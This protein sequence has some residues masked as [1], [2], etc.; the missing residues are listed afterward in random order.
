MPMGSSWSEGLTGIAYEIAARESRLMRVCAGPGTGKTFAMMRR[1]GRF[2]E[3][4]VPPE[5]ILVVTFTRAAARDL[6]RSLV[7]IDHPEA[8]K[9]VSGTLHSHCF[10]VLQDEAV[11]SLTGRTPRPLLKHEHKYLEQDLAGA[12]GLKSSQTHIA[13]FEAEWARAQTDDPGWPTDNRDQAFHGELMGWMQFHQAMLIGELVSETRK[14][15]KANPASPHASEFSHVLVDEYQDLNRADQETI[16]SLAS[17]ASLLVVGDED[18][19][20]YGQ[21]RYAQPEGIRD[22]PR[23]HPDT[24]S[25]LMEECRRC[26]KQVVSLANSLI[27]RNGDREPHELLE[28]APNTDDEVVEIVQWGS[29]EE[30]SFGLAQAIQKIIA[31]KENGISAQDVMVLVPRRSVGHAIKKALDILGVP[32]R[33]EFTEDVL[34]SKEA[35]RRYGFLNLLASPEDRVALRVLLGLGMSERGAKPYARLRR[36]CEQQDQSPF[37][38]MDNIVRGSIQIPYVQTLVPAWQEAIG[39]IGQHLLCTDQ[40]LIDGLFPESHADLRVLRTMAMQTLLQHKQR[41]E[42]LTASRLFT[43]IREQVSTPAELSEGGDFVQIM[44]LHQSKG[45]TAKAVVVAGVVQGWI[46]SIDHEL[47]GSERQRQLSE[48][49]RLFYVAITR[50]TERMILS[51][52]ISMP[53]T[54]A[55]KLNVSTVKSSNGQSRV[56]ASVFLSELGIRS[57]KP[58]M[59]LS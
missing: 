18:Q 14:F 43:S 58:K 23:T 2:L 32:A 53:T 7:R 38:V 11:L 12:N 20:I 24:D 13:A 39:F 35:Q 56:I 46:P 48:Q 45:L 3:E 8:I 25:L 55:K 31:E 10:R 59:G 54:D 19:S 57:P 40:T 52:F 49:R 1:V 5:K 22:F 28:H 27:S 34:A 41:G 36:Y 37:D 6:R 42:E 44:T 30:E 21:L 26:P 47:K 51:S 16:E 33:T 29:Q 9:V 50:C 15:L 17:H 4:G